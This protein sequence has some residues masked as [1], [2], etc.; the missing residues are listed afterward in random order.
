MDAAGL[1][2]HYQI[3]DM[4]RT[5]TVEMVDAGVPL[6]QI[7]SVTGHANPQSVKPYLKNTLAS[8]TSALR[9]RYEYKLA[10]GANP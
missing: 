9:N 1:P 7:M 8:A 5:G 3:M 4:R 2:Q 6:A 10:N